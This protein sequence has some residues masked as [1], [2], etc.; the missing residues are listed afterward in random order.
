MRELEGVALITGAAGA[1][2]RAVARA[3]AARGMS[4]CLVDREC[5]G[6]RDCAAELGAQLALAQH[7]DLSLDQDLRRLVERVG[8]EPGH[9]DVLVH[10]AGVIKLGDVEAA[11]WGD[12]DEQY[13]V[14]VR[15]AYLLTQALLPLLRESQGQIV[16]L[17]SSAALCA[18][19]DDVLYAAT[20][21]ALRSLADGVRSRVNPLGIRVLS[22]FPGRTASRMQE[23]VHAFEGRSYR[24]E[25]LLQPE[26]VAEVIVAGLSLPRT[27]EL[28]EVFVRPMKKPA[29]GRSCP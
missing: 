11:A 13:R 8:A 19:A 21:G 18:G 24:P 6:L 10:S 4:L 9:L 3:L 16:F 28:T 29:S 2:G 20:K 7:A 23:A 27:A 15:A 12:L 25:E 17:N 26:D 5:E 1:I 14:N 22:V